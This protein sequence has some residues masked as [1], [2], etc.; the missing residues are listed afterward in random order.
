MAH[1]HDHHHGHGH[2]HG[3]G[4]ARYDR[5]FAL[6]VVLNLV[7]VV[8][9]AI[10]GVLSGSLALL[11]DAGHNLSDVLGLLLAWGASYL[12]R[13]EASSWRTYGMRKTTILAAL[14]NALILL[15]A[16]GGIT[17]EAITRL[18]QPTEIASVTVI[19][20][21]GI[22]VIINAATML[23]FMANRSEDL[24]I[25]GAFLH[26]AADAGISLGVVIAAVVIL[27]TGAQWLDPLI[28][29]V[30]AVIIFLGTWGLLRDSL[31]L[32]LD[33]VPRGMDPAAI[34]D[35]LASLPGVEEAHDLHIWGLS[36]TETALTAHLVKP[37]SRDDDAV[38]E[39]A[40]R[41]LAERFNITHVTLQWERSRRLC[42][43][44]AA[45]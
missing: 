20:V 43:S 40:A 7:F 25:R 12:A 3:H 17:W 27:F 30:I 36:T 16:L 19:V 13:R 44:G 33:A 10:Y 42:P 39:E 5:R 35:Y 2:G 41:V 4:V 21:A 32:A 18:N 1:S 22:G 9:E 14:F 26:M 11:A 37:D 23:L 31:N 45:C 29:L 34:H 38:I 24:N 6:A 15:V 8:I 28:S